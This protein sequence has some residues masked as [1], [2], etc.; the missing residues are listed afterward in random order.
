MQTIQPGL[1]EQPIRPD[2][3]ELKD[4]ILNIIQHEEPIKACQ[5]AYRLTRKYGTTISRHDVNSIL[6]SNNGLRGIVIVS[7]TDFKVY[8]RSAAQANP[9]PRLIA[10][11]VRP[12]I[13]PTLIGAPT[14][15]LVQPDPIATG[16]VVREE[17]LNGRYLIRR[18]IGL[19]YAFLAF[20]IIKLLL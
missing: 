14:Q 2:R 16:G 19:G 3:T 18:A 12:K 10:K 4:A 5:I 20:E 6:F 1:F 7:R 8:L 9:Q 13:E 15:P 11:P 17:P